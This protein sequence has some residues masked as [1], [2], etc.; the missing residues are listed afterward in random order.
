[1]CLIALLHKDV[2]TSSGISGTAIFQSNLLLSFLLLKNGSS[3][4]REKAAKVIFTKPSKPVRIEHHKI[5]FHESFSLLKRYRTKAMNNSEKAFDT[6]SAVGQ[7][8]ERK[9]VGRIAIEKIMY[10]YVPERR[11]AEITNIIEKNSVKA[12][13]IRRW[14]PPKMLGK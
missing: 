6:A 1:M 13:E 9:K 2:V 11:R 5:S 14:P 3:K 7:I 10:L 8:I 4:R 12:A